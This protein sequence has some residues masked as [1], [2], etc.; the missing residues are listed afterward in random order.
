MGDS[1][2]VFWIAEHVKDCGFHIRTYHNKISILD[3][4]N[5][6]I[7][8]VKIEKKDGDIFV[9]ALS[10]SKP[11]PKRNYGLGSPFIHH[12]QNKKL[13]TVAL[14]DDTSINRIDEWLKEIQSKLR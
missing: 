14:H 1:K 8:Q 2:V 12:S 7:Y 5:I 4:N 11:K 9:H 3:S 6:A 10:V 13:F